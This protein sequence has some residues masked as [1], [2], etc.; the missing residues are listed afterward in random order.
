MIETRWATAADL[1]GFAMPRKTA[2][3]R[4]ALVDGRPAAILGYVLE[5][6]FAMVFS[7]IREALPKKLIVREALAL[8]G[9]LKVPAGCLAD[10]AHPGSCRF[11]ERLG[12]IPV[13]EIEQGKV[14]AWRR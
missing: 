4:V 10:R 6:D 12:W 3:V 14:Y 8:M 11:L 9:G 2:R 7:E 1:E 5:R 13:G